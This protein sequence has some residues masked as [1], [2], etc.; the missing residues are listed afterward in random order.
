MHGQDIF[1]GIRQVHHGSSKEVP[2]GNQEGSPGMT[3]F[4]V[5][6]EL[7]SPEKIEILCYI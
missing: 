4:V 2:E 6:A 1:A 7:G 5:L 3:G